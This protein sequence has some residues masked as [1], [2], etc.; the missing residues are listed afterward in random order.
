MIHMVDWTLPE[1]HHDATP[2]PTHPPMFWSITMRLMGGFCCTVMHG[3]AMLE[4]RATTPVTVGLLLSNGPTRPILKCGQSLSWS[5][6]WST[7]MAVALLWCLTVFYKTSF[8]G[9]FAMI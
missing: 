4:N 8:S 1:D 5:W 2:R 7:R 9:E 6:H 3:V